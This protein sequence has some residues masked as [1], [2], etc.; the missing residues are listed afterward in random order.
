MHHTP[1]LQRLTRRA[2]RN[3]G[4]RAR[5]ALGALVLLGIGG[6]SCMSPPGDPHQIDRLAETVLPMAQAALDANQIEMARRLYARLL[7]AAPQSVEARMGLGRVAMAER[8]PGQAASWHLSALSHADAPEERHAALLAHGRAALA[9]GQHAEAL[10]SF[11]RLAHPDEKAPARLVA[12]GLNG[13]GVVRWMEGDPQG[14]VDAMEQA[15]L[16]DPDEPAFRGNMA[17]AVEMLATLD[18]G[19]APDPARAAALA[20]DMLTT[21]PTARQPIVTAPVPAGATPPAPDDGMAAA[22]PATASPAATRCRWWLFTWP[23]EA[24]PVDEGEAAASAR[25]AAAPR[26]AQ[27]AADTELADGVAAGEDSDADDAPVDAA[28]RADSDLATTRPAAIDRAPRSGGDAAQPPGGE[29]MATAMSPPAADASPTFEADVP[30]N[31]A[32][33]AAGEGEEAA[34]PDAL[35]LKTAAA[36][37]LARPSF[38]YVQGSYVFSSLDFFSSLDLSSLEDE[39]Q[40][41]LAASVE[42]G[43]SFHLWGGVD[44]GWVDDVPL[45]LDDEV[46]SSRLDSTNVVSSRLDFTNVA[47]GAGFHVE[48]GKALL[49]GRAGY[50][51]SEVDIDIDWE[52]VCPTVTVPCPPASTQNDGALVE[53]GVRAF[54]AAP[55]E[56]SAAF[57]FV[58]FGEAGDGASFRIEAEGPLAGNWKWRLGWRRND[59]DEDAFAVAL[60]FYPRWRSAVGGTQTVS[61][62][63]AESAERGTAEAA[64]MESIPAAAENGQ[65]AP[66][67]PMEQAPP[68]SNVKPAPAALEEPAPAAKAEVG[69]P[70]TH[71]LTIADEDLPPAAAPDAFG[72]MDLEERVRNLGAFVFSAG[73]GEYAQLAA[74]ST[75]DAALALVERVREMTDFDVFAVEAGDVGG[76]VWR[77]RAGPLD[78]RAELARFVEQLEEGGYPG[79]GGNGRPPVGAAE[80]RAGEADADRRA[81]A[82][83]DGSGSGTVGGDESDAGT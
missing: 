48:A 4:L 6:T 75:R 56:L 9:A 47:G 25:P 20:P 11:A 63:G 49:Y 77:V 27:A 34:A 36:S 7:E 31:G 41:G 35:D 16:R 50:L 57:T 37:A 44:R 5:S 15:V 81:D 61:D 70:G 12:W 39:G 3:R 67:D 80:T 43:D 33:A 53:G 55:L 51:F 14:A 23:C 73:H 62:R 60:R 66:M 78:G 32:T 59:D 24:P 28:D 64:A 2:N 1:I 76:G 83:G 82:D 40:A 45:L 71:T 65:P 54:V 52:V 26:A 19:S 17:A 42:L 74:L 46:V 21:A 22:S 30:A 18:L 10:R 68:G 79:A 8:N 69:S 58:D 38:T 29:D 13:V 72:A